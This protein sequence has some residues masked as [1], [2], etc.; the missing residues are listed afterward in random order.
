MTSRFTETDFCLSS[1]AEYWNL[2]PEILR[3]LYGEA[4]EG[5][6]QEASLQAWLSL[7]PGNISAMI[8]LALRQERPFLPPGVTPEMMAETNDTLP[9]MN[10]IE[11]LYV[12]TWI[13]FTK[14]FFI[15]FWSSKTLLCTCNRLDHLVVYLNEFVLYSVTQLWLLCINTLLSSVTKRPMKIKLG[16]NN[17][18]NGVS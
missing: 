16:E 3:Q 1:A 7:L 17:P 8:Q 4:S 5:A 13:Y 18:S 2:F 9:C 15:S 14:C 10:H 11:I 6:S 12:G